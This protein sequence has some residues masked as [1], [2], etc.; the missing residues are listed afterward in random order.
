MSNTIIFVVV[1][2]LLVLVVLRL[3]TSIL[4]A[5]EEFLIQRN[6]NEE[7]IEPNENMTLQDCLELYFDNRRVVINNG[8]VTE[9]I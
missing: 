1:S 7:Y 6:A 3:L 9:I 5:I 4:Y 2:L 8:Q